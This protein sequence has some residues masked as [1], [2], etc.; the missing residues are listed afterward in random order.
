MS[1]VEV[2]RAAR[3]KIEQGWTQRAIARDASGLA[4]D[5]GEDFA[6]AWCLAGA[7]NST[8]ATHAER[9]EAYMALSD[10]CSGANSIETWNDATGRTQ[11]EVLDRA[12]EKL[13]RAA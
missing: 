9:V 13:A 6:C 12:I 8:G 10:H 7:V 1:P 5:A 2:L 4:C 11:A 3:A